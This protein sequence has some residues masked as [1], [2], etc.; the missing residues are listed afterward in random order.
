MSKLSC[1]ST[2]PARSL[3]SYQLFHSSVRVILD[4]LV[5]A[6]QAGGVEMTCADRLVRKVLPVVA[7]YVAD[8]PEQ[9]LIAGCQENRCPIGTIMPDRRGEHEYCAPRDQRETLD[10]LDMHRQG[11]L[12]ENLK[13]R[14]KDLGL[15]VVYEPFWRDLPYSDIFQ[16]FTPDLLH[17]LHKGVFKDHLV[18]WCTTLI[19]ERELDE[20]FICTPTLAGLRHFR[21]GISGVSQWTGHEHKEMEKVFLGLV[22]G[23][24][25]DEVVLAVRA[26]MDFVYLASLQSHTTITLTLLQEA[27]DNFHRHKQAFIDLGARDPPH[28]NIPKYHMLEH[29]VALIKNFGSA[30]GFNTEW[31]ERLHIDYAKDAYRASNKKDYVVQMTTWLAR[32]EAVDRF[33]VYLEW[34]KSGA[35]VPHAS[36]VLDTVSL[37]ASDS[38]TPEASVVLLS[39]VQTRHRHYQVAATHPPALRAIPAEKVIRGQKAAQF[40]SALRT[41]LHINGSSVVPYS[42]DGFDLY[43]QLVVTLPGIP[44]V[45]DNKLRNVIRASP[46]SQKVGR[47]PAE[48]AQL[49]FALIRTGEANVY[50]DGTALEG[51]S[52]YS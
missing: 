43:K 49:D 24:A 6:G 40:L 21:K 25:D 50:T 28:F 48:P 8:Y 35:Y 1:F 52:L 2:K 17:Q 39:D 47:K 31:S 29:Y 36:H 19:G 32:Q 16:C 33:S 11:Q 14:F 44:E 20:R 7:A 37:P 13:A 26:L 4:E 23:V 22:A 30:D 46:P 34:F 15:R 12:T 42:F 27:L 10:L 51:V 5:K 18:K 45:S 38:E 9:C 3:A 41:F